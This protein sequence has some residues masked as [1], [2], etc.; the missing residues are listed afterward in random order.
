ML[1]ENR[2]RVEEAQ[3]RKEEE[4]LRELELIQRLLEGEELEK[5]K[6]MQA[7]HLWAR[8]SLGQRMIGL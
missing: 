4:R 2:R 3:R 1:E 6:S 5:R 7:R 8:T